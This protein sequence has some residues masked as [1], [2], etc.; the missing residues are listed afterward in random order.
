MDRDDRRP[1][2]IASRTTTESAAPQRG[3]RPG[4]RRVT[5]LLCRALSH[6]L[7]RRLVLGGGLVIA[8]WTAGG[9]TQAHADQFAPGELPARTHAAPA[10]ATPA[11]PGHLRSAP[12]GHL[13]SV[14]RD[15]ASAH[16]LRSLIG[17]ALLD[18]ALAHS[19]ARHTRFALVD[20]ARA[21][22]S[23]SHTES[24]PRERAAAPHVQA[25]TR[26]IRR[27][28]PTPAIQ[29][30]V[31]SAVAS[32]GTAAVSRTR[33]RTVV[34]KL[35]ASLVRIRLGRERERAP[36][37]HS[38]TGNT[39][40]GPPAHATCDQACRRPSG[41]SATIPAAGTPPTFPSTVGPPAVPGAVR[42]PAFPGAVEGPALPG[43]RAAQPRAPR[44]VLAVVRV[45][46]W[47]VGLPLRMAIR[48]LPDLLP[49]PLRGPAWDLIHDLG[50]VRR[51]V[52]IAGP[53]RR[54]GP[55]AYGQ[56]PQQAHTLPLAIGP[57]RLPSLQRQPLLSWTLR[58][59]PPTYNGSTTATDRQHTDHR[60]RRRH[61]PPI[62]P[63]PSSDPGTGR[64]TQQT[65]GAGEVAF[66][67][68][69]PPTLW[70]ITKEPVPRVDR[71]ISDKPS[72]SPD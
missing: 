1:G 3:A 63:A 24:A 28:A 38:P 9:L 20:R 6:A 10:H 65:N 7:L 47:K 2:C 14:S 58:K 53:P 22:P 46:Q 43:G 62:V 34:A 26:S 32:R 44:Q 12:P 37:R 60:V 29:V 23:P 54:Y 69:R 35:V 71:N 33:P 66:P 49:P 25:G 31:G 64:N 59:T 61:R 27:A 70:S 36:T 21:H 72:F 52:P 5:G 56:C 51:A 19:F 42:P 17:S 45:L 68:L 8:A 16:P 57:P 55:G 48:H 41:Q 39:R 30:R 11:P 40:D 15:H 50:T 18:R 13:R 67:T 4:N